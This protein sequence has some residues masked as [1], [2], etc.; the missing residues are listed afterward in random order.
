MAGF[1]H[2][3]EKVVQTLR[4]G[5]EV[6]LAHEVDDGLVEIEIRFRHSRQ[7][8]FHRKNP[9]HIVVI[10]VEHREPC[11]WRRPV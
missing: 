8:V 3:L 9:D 6:S 1:L 2:F 10:G 5:D 4:F 11:V 7:N